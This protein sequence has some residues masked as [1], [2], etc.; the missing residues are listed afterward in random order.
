MEKAIQIHTRDNVAT[1]TGDVAASEEVGVL[2]PQGELN[3]LSLR[4]VFEQDMILKTRKI[5]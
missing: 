1:L 4:V 2:S 3:F 5:R